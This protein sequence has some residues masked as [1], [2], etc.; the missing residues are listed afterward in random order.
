[1]R[2]S[3]ARSECYAMHRMP[4]G[5]TVP[6]FG[7]AVAFVAA[8]LLMLQVTADPATTSAGCSSIRA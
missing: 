8:V 2:I 3:D 7:L 1:M 6:G 5:W 4:V